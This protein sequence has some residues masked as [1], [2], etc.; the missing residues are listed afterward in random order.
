MAKPEKVCPATAA[1]VRE[2]L[3]ADLGMDAPIK[4]ACGVKSNVVAF[5]YPAARRADAESY[6][7]T[8]GGHV[9]DIRAGAEQSCPCVETKKGKS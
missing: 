5:N 1:N 3:G 7:R 2:W 4:V 8:H 6:V 9:V